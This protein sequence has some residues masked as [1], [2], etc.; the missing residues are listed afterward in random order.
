MPAGGGRRQYIKCG[1]P[2]KIRKAKSADKKIWE[3]R[4]LRGLTPLL[5]GCTRTRVPQIRHGLWD[6]VAVVRGKSVSVLGKR[7]QSGIVQ[8]TDQPQQMNQQ[9]KYY[10]QY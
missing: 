7:Y 1:S 4:M 9:G 10:L 8:I 6:K 2:S 5:R 3:T